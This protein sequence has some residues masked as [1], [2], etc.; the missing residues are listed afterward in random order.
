MTV[1]VPQRVYEQLAAY[2]NDATA[3]GVANDAIRS[4]HILLSFGDDEAAQWISQDVY[5]YMRARRSGIQPVSYR[6]DCHIVYKGR[7]KLFVIVH[8]NE[9]IM[10]EIA[11]KEVARWLLGDG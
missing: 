8:N 5:R 1:K 4:M 7:T 9:E 6:D 3:D 2:W 11:G 10:T